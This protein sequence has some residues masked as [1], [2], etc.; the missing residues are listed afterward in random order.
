MRNK[1]GLL[2][3]VLLVVAAYVLNPGYS[4]HLVK[5]GMPPMLSEP[6]SRDNPNPL[7]NLVVEYHN[8]YLFST[9]TNRFTGKG[10]TLGLFGVVI[11]R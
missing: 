2:V 8:Y 6:L 11:R 9:T 3:I 1:T 10:T 4:K 7:S 5:L